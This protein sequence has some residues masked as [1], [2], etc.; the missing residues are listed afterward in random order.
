MSSDAADLARLRALVELRRHAE[1]EPGLRRLLA[2]DPGNVEVLLLLADVVDELGRPEE[3]C[4]LAAS[5]VAQAPD[6]EFAHRMLA[7]TLRRAG[8]H[9]EAVAAA[10]EA[11]RLDPNFWATHYT[12]GMTLREG[13]KPRYRDALDCANAAIRLAPDISHGYNLAGMCCDNLLLP[14]E[15]LRAYTEALRLDPTSPTILNNIAA[16][17]A[18]RGNLVDASRYLTAGLSQDAQEKFLRQNYDVILH[19]LIRR[20]LLAEFGFGI[21][22]AILAAVGAPHLVRA[23]AGVAMVAT[24]VLTTRG[25]L[26]ALPRG[27]HRHARG[28][29]ARSRGWTRFSLVLFVITSLAVL[30]MAVTPTAV[31][32]A[33]GLGFLTLLRTAGLGIVVVAV[34]G[35]LVNLV[36]R[37]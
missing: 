18:D 1:A 28:L 34:V 7:Q 2:S 4:E 29:L 17:E 20:L 24:F 31:S 15:A 36:R 37:K 16:H 30:A 19:K 9:D 32:L 12:L 6:S 33:I 22:I 5:A 14:D 35:A 11:V 8:R 3:A 21:L 13:R 23:L 25:V 27:S 26:D 10:R